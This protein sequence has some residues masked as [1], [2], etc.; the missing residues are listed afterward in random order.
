MILDGCTHKKVSLKPFLLE[1]AIQR[2]KI[3]ETLTNNPKELQSK[4][5]L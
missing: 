1:N 5:H 4:I 2:G 3:K